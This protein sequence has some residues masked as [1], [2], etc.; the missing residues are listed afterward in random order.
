MPLK[1]YINT[2][3]YRECLKNI[4]HFVAVPCTRPTWTLANRNFFLFR[5]ETACNGRNMLFLIQQI[6]RLLH[7]HAKRKP[8]LTLLLPK[9][10]KSYSCT[11]TCTEPRTEKRETNMLSTY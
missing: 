3:G 4:H 1:P 7:M 6:L 2:A 10:K 5:R 9:Y 11:Y 8:N